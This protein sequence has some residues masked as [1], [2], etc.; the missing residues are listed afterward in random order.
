MEVAILGAGMTGL[1]AAKAL[2]ELDIDFLIFDK[3]PEQATSV[4]QGLHYLHDNCGLELEPNIVHN[5]VIGYNPGEKMPH[6][7]YSEKLGTP[8]NNSLV[9]LPAYNI[10]YDF[11]MAYHMLYAMFSRKIRNVTIGPEMLEYLLS[12]PDYTIST[13]PLCILFPEADCKF[14]EVQ[15]SRGKPPGLDGVMNFE[16]NFVI[17]N[18]DKED[19]WYRYSK[20]FGVEWAE[21]VEGGDFTI[22]KVVDTDFESPYDN[23][24]LLGRWGQWKRKFLAHH[25]YYEIKRRFQ[26]EL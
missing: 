1:L 23:I 6:E 24:I 9:D 5:Y 16:E 8:L 13:I 22:K 18:L 3:N 21:V 7:V 12:K 19:A 17:Y 2:S 11:N 10:I 26:D 15:A 20:I 14:V 4:K 25:A